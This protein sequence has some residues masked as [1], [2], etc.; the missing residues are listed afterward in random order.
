MDK[1]E[2]VFQKNYDPYIPAIYVDENQME[3]VLINL[4][5]NALD[6]MQKGDRMTV[7]IRSEQ[8]TETSTTVVVLDIEDTGCGI[9][10]ENL[11]KIFNPFYTTKNDG[12]GLGLS[13]SSR[14]IEENGGKISVE[15]DLEKGT[16]FT[17]YLPTT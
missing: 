11:E 13:I 5:L 16:R 7:N 2:I 1:K 8:D 12:V 9:K 3:Q 17:I 10:A 15:S 4:F 14:L 6:S